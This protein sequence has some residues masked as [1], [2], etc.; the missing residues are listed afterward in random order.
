MTTPSVRPASRAST[1]VALTALVPLVA[2]LSV[3]LAAC[4]GGEREE[5]AARAI[6]DS[7]VAAQVAAPGGATPAADQPS[8]PEF[9][10]EESAITTTN[11]G[12]TMA[13]AGEK[14]VVHLSDSVVGQVRAKMD[15]GSAHD[16]GSFG[17]MIARMAKSAVAT[18]LTTALSYPLSEIQDARYEDGAIR[19]TFADGSKRAIENTKV[20][21]RPLLASFAESDARRFVAAV[22]AAKGRRP[23]A[24]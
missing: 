24:R 6:A 7:V 13:I 22:K 2:G 10:N 1:R 19:F 16:S 4:G 18:G 17:G 8:Q 21:D 12:V 9:A 15:S 23:E 5:E 14:L 3:G 20:D 11:G